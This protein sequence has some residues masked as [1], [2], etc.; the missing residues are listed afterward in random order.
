MMSS[1]SC[2]N[3]ELMGLCMSFVVGYEYVVV[4]VDCLDEVWC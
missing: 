3:S 1:V 2:L 4:F